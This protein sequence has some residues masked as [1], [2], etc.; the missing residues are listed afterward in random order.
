[1]P[2]C[3]YARRKRKPPKPTRAPKPWLAVVLAVDTAT[4]SGWA[5]YASGRLRA[6]GE[7]ST[8]DEG[9]LADI[10]VDA[11]RRAADGGLPLVL[12]LEASFGGPTYVVTALGQA[13]E[14]WLRAWRDAGQ[15]MRRVVLVQP[16]SWRAVML[17][18]TLRRAKRD[19]LRAAEAVVASGIVGRAV[20]PDEAAAVLIGRW[21]ARSLPVGKSLGKTWMKRSVACWRAQS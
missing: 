20:E 9:A 14:R 12:V 8:R 7:V 2:T 3:Q 15:E 13:R 10:V 18:P 5:L 17:D 6:S 19:A 4:R 21:A 1:L 16:Q 11:A